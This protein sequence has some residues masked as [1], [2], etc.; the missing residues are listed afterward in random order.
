MGD[1]EPCRVFLSYNAHDKDYVKSLAAALSMAGAHVWFDDWKI[2]PGD[3]IPGAIDEGLRNFDIFALVWSEAASRSQWVK[4]E[5]E[6]AVSRWIETPEI[7][8]V[9][10]ILDATPLP[11]ILRP[12]KYINGSDHNSPRVAR[13]LLGIESEAAF[14]LAVQRFI[15]SA[16]LEFRE[17]WGAGVYVAC[18]RCGASSDQLEGW[19]GTDEERDDR[20]AGAY[21]K[22]CDWSEG[23]EL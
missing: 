22:V 6:S 11:A 16:G 12:I 18:P 7:R 1:K 2:R 15:E 4:R 8:L 5:M 9:P 3:S 20:Y 13:E 21:C 17:F 10:A 19:S 23:S 14:R